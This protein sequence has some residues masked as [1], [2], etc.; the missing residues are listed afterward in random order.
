MENDN[1]NVFARNLNN[2]MNARG[3]SRKELSEV[4]GISY[5]TITAWTNGTKYPRMDKVEMLANYFGVLKSDLIEDKSSI[6]NTVDDNS[7][8]VALAE[9]EDI[10]LK[11]LRKVPEDKREAVTHAIQTVLDAYK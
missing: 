5:F 10:L 11:A 9:Y 1:K 2:L 7:K 6:E 3:K 4:L 8:S